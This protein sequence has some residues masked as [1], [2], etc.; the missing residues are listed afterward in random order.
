MRLKYTA[1]AKRDIS[2]LYR[3]SL[4]GFGSAHADRYL[5]RLEGA[6]ASL[7]EFPSASAERSEY[8]G[9]VR[10]R[11]FE[12]HHIIYTVAAGQV[13][14]VRVLHGRQDLQKYLER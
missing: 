3:A 4:L 5:R 10:I 8:R 12:A 6:L 11:R 14:V 2:G 13:L 1:A 7:T 9:N